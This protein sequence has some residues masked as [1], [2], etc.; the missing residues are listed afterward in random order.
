MWPLLTSS[1]RSLWIFAYPLVEFSA[2]QYERVV[3]RFE[4]STFG[5]D[6]SS[7]VDVVSGHHSYCYTGPLTLADCI[8]HL[9]HTQHQIH[10]CAHIQPLQNVL[11][12][13]ARLILHKRKYDRITS[14][15]RDRL[16][17]LPIQQRLGYKIC[18]LIFKCLH[19]TAPV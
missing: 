19:Q 13:A 15:I 4:N 7:R 11:N 17:W 9:R 14:D 16:H 12:A 10:T 5:S 8:R 2:V 1:Y 3:S 18:L 6:T